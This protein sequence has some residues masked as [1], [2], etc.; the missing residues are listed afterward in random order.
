MGTS[1]REPQEE[2]TYCEYTSQGPHIPINFLLSYC[3]SLFGV[4]A[5]VVLFSGLLQCRVCGLE[6]KIFGS[7]LRA[8][9]V[10]FMVLDLGSRI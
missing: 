2:G 6:F 9:G 7:G 10:G 4:P 8:C 1:N 5:G 3:G